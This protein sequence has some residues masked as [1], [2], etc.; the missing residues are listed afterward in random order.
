MPFSRENI[1]LQLANIFGFARAHSILIIVGVALL[2]FVALGIQKCN[3]RHTERL[4]DKRLQKY[5]SEINR[6]LDDYNRLLES[7]TD[8]HE[9]TR[10]VL[11]VIGKISD[12]INAL[13]DNNRVITKRVNEIS[14][15]EYRQARTQRND[16]QAIKTGKAKPNRKPLK[17]RELD[18]LK[19]DEDLYPDK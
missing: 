7:A 16:Q 10:E 15:G 1:R 12:T 2:L 6:H 8:N 14:E 11:G 18:V 4:E 3:D 19:S 13:A 17:T 9:K 5:D